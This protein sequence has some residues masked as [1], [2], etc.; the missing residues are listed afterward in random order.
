MSFCF[1]FDLRAACL[2]HTLVFSK[3]SDDLNKFVMTYIPLVDYLADTLGIGYEIALYE[4]THFLK[5]I[6]V[7]NSYVTERCDAGAIPSAVRKIIEND[8]ISQKPYYIV[9]FMSGKSERPI[10]STIYC[11]RDDAGGIVGL[12]SISKG[13]TEFNNEIEI[14]LERDG[15]ADAAENP[16]RQA[17]KAGTD[18]KG[19]RERRVRNAGDN[20]FFLATL[21]E[22]VNDLLSEISSTGIILTKTR[23][24]EI[25]EKLYQ[26]GVFNIKGAVQEVA[27]L[28]KTS[29]TTIYRHIR[30]IEEKAKCH[31]TWTYSM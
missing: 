24:A 2:Y 6:I 22:R 23:K 12:L 29:E 4:Y 19:N 30:A 18:S 14:W 16:A 26:E 28:L 7:R 11:I 13:K 15:S 3:E 25:I 20:S 21:Q 27:S 9:E 5:T 17:P 31:D 1:L 10:K 8:E